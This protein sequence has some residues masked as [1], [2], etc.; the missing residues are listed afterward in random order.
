M[1]DEFLRGGG[2]SRGS[3]NLFKIY[4]VYNARLSSFFLF[5][6]F[7]SHHK[8]CSEQN[9]CL[10]V[11]ERSLVFLGT[12]PQSISVMFL[13]CKFLICI[14]YHFAKSHKAVMLK[15][16]ELYTGE[17]KGGKKG[18][19]ISSRIGFIKIACISLPKRWCSGRWQGS[20]W[21]GSCIPI[22]SCPHGH[23]SHTHFGDDFECLHI[24]GNGNKII[25]WFSTSLTLLYRS[26]QIFLFL[27]YS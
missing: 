13:E 7:F 10:A 24:S 9:S 5:F 2:V 23:S 22:P 21:L 17:E 8:S 4:L 25:K 27:F 16:H 15:C 11:Q 26:V 18:T 14:R 6:V 20:G 12:S 19:R 1:C 3:R